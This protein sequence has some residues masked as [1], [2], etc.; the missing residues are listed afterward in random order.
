VGV[1]GQRHAAAVLSLD[2]HCIGGWYGL[3]ARLVGYEEEN[4]LHLPLPTGFEPLNV[5]PEA[6]SYTHR[7]IPAL[8]SMKPLE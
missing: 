4:L 7:A 8:D 6:S 2:T 3:S 5:Q 1:G